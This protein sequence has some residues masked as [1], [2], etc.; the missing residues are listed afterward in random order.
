MVAGHDAAQAVP[1]HVHAV[2]AGLL[3]DLLDVLRRAGRRRPD[4]LHERAVVP[5]ADRGEAT[6]PQRGASRRRSSGCRP[7]RA[8]ARPAPAP[9]GGRR[10]RAPRT[11]G[12][13]AGADASRA[14]AL[15]RVPSG[16]MSAWAPTQA[17]SVSPPVRVVGVQRARS[18]R[19]AP[20][21]TR[22]VRRRRRARA[23]WTDED[24][25]SRPRDRLAAAA[26]THVPRSPDGNAPVCPVT[27]GLSRSD[28]SRPLVTPA[29]GDP[30][31]RAGTAP[32]QRRPAGS[33]TP[34]AQPVAPH[35]RRTARS[36][37]PPPAA[38]G[39]R[40]SVRRPVVLGGCPPCPRGGG[41]AGAGRPGRRRRLFPGYLVSRQLSVPGRRP[42]ACWSPCHAPG[43]AR[44]R[45]AGSRGAPSPC[46]AWPTRGRRGPG[47]SATC[48]SSS[49]RAP[50]RPP[51]PGVEV[52]GR[53]WCSPAP[54]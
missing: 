8:P 20:E 33:R 29:E 41:P 10:R 25:S 37:P 18:A 42:A 27:H 50:P 5:G 22:R 9:R 16:Y 15:G 21:R 51:A 23:G 1:D 53:G 49:T 38:A 19:A 4:V 6:T 43:R 54:W 45:R 35:L 13:C 30:W 14:A 34:G 17:S 26:V 40:R 31:P 52:L 11:G 3:A 7:S 12:C 48:S 47:R 36:A 28:R 46:S 32:R 2:V 44:R 39:R 24:P